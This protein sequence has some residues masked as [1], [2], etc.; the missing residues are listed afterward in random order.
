MFDALLVKLDPD[1]RGAP[2]VGMFS[3]IDLQSF[4]VCSVV[5]LGTLLRLVRAVSCSFQVALDLGEADGLAGIDLQWSGIDLGRIEK[6]LPGNLAVYLPGELLVGVDQDKA[7]RD[8]SENPQGQQHLGP[9]RMKPGPVPPP[10]LYPGLLSRGFFLLGADHGQRF[11]LH[12]AGRDSGISETT[13]AKPLTAGRV[14][15]GLVSPRFSGSSVA[16]FDG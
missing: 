9:G 14:P 6:N 3:R 11:P 13:P 5:S 1:S 4:S 10:G 15:P 2:S 8:E 7:D 12:P 16:G